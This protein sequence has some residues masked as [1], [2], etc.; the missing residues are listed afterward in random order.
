MRRIL[1]LCLLLLKTAALSQTVADGKD[2]PSAQPKDLIRSFVDDDERIALRGNLH[3]LARSEFDRGAVSPNYRMDRMI[4]ALNLD[5]ER[6][7]ILDGLVREQ[8][9]PG[10]PHY[11]QWLT[12]EEYGEHF[13]ISEND[14]EQVLNW[15]RI[16]GMKI[17]EVTAGRRAIIFSGTAAQVDLAFHTPIHIYR[18]GDEVHHAN[19]KNPQIPRAL[20]NVVNGVVSLHDFRSRPMHS[21]ARSPRPE[22]S[23]GGGHYLAPADFTTIYDVTP[24]YGQSINGTGQSVAIV[25][26][27]NI[28]LADVQ[29]FRS[30]FGLPAN[31]PQI[32]VNGANPGVLSS[33]EEVEAD[34]DVE[35]AGAVAK[36]ATINFVVSASTNSSDGTYL[37]AQYIVSHNLAPVM[38][39]SF[40][41]CEAALGASGNNFLNSLWQQAAAQ[42]ITVFVSSGDSGAAGCDSSSASRASAGTGVN[43]LC[44]TPYSVCVGGT[45]FNEASN[46]GAYWSSSN[47]SAQGSALSYIPEVAWNESSGGGLWAGGGGVS[48]VYSKPSWQTGTGVPADGRRDVPDV[49]LSSAGH[50]GYLIYMNGGEYVVGGTSAASPS[51]AG[52]MALVVQN[53]AA[54]QGNANTAFYALAGKQAAGGAAVFHDTTS[55]NNSVPGVTGFS[56]GTGYDRATGLGSVDA[57]VMVNH[58]SDATAVPTFQASL[59]TGLIAVTAG[60]STSTNLN[61]TVSGG[62]N[63]KVSFSATGLPAGVSAAFTPTSL[64]APG[65]GT[66]VFKLVASSSAKA[67]TYSASVSATSGSTVQKVP[68][69][70]TVAPAPTFA[71]GT[72]QTSVSVPAGGSGTVT[73]TTNGNSTFNSTVSFSVS[74][75]PAGVT[76]AFAPTTIGAP[77]SGSTVITFNASSTV[78]AKSYSIV[79]TA[80]GGGVTKTTNVTANVPGFTLVPSATAISVSGSSTKGS[81][82]L[83]TTPLGGFASSIALSVSGVPNGISASFSP[84]SLGAPGSG[85]ATLTLTR[86]TGAS[87]GSAK[88]TVT[89]NGGS[90]QHTAAISLNVSK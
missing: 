24:L 32:I 58:W 59:P 67:G 63:T 80:T 20:A 25:A 22:F 26:R 14:L 36:N 84:Q 10:S 35:W 34:L 48:T 46:A 16:H 83:T 45:Q 40:G 82:T 44:S 50:D 23:S 4:L 81:V 64:P 55:G 66:S 71:L 6:Q 54:R 39:V 62:F 28:H 73:L 75:L 11:H 15:L 42:G 89:A 76:A 21:E 17:E 27:S 53:A 51:F 61:V 8:Q 52:L 88:L 7:Q 72:A 57:S 60:S 13:G 5:V 49:S 33:G 2:L 47:N 79:V 77:G 87:V 29:A 78:T 56:A 38:S 30:M 9:N 1:L 90:I 37:S 41:L 65:S 74:G 70:V 68:F 86:G 69:S 12:P 31:N 18:V 43:G 85:R 3:P 19:A